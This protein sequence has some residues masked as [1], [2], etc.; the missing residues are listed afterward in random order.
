MKALGFEASNEETKRMVKEMDRDNSG[1]I[2]FEEF[3]AVVE[4]KMAEKYALQEMRTLFHLYIDPTL[5]LHNARQP[6]TPA[7]QQQRGGGSNALTR[8]SASDLRRVAD[9][10]GEKLSDDEIREM[11]EEADRDNDGEVTEEDFVRV[12]KKTSLW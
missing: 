4:R 8:I 5:S 11:I 1:T 7:P 9:L 10:I 6:H 2:D 3:L 12:M